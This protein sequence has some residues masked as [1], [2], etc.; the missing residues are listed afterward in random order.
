MNHSQS[1]QYL[2]SYSARLYR[3]IFWL[4]AVYNLSFGLWA[5]FLP[6]LFFDLFKLEPPQY[7]AI[8]QCLGMVIG[9]YGIL[10]GYAALRLERATPIIAVG[11]LGKVLGVIGW[12]LTVGYGEF[13]LRTFTLI[14]L[15]DI[16][17]WLPFALFITHRTRAGRWIRGIAPYACAAFLFLASTAILFILQGVMEGVPEISARKEYI[18]QNQFMWR[19]GW[20]IFII[21]MISIGGFYAW[22]GAHLSS[23]NLAIA[24]L[25]LIIISVSSDLLG[26]SLSLAWTPQNL[27]TIQRPAS[28][29]TAGFANGLNTIA[30]VILTLGTRS[31]RGWLLIF[32]WTVWIIGFGLSAATLANSIMGI[33]VTAGLQFTIYPLWVAVFGWKLKRESLA[34]LGNGVPKF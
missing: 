33:Y 28:I 7:Q 25:M 29:L 34:S 3:I 19:F 8:W 2:D 12:I 4:A 26:I 21:A 16:I 30:G 17:W 1:L 11:L 24:A 9:V 22:W 14:L 10:Y 18:L 31:L 6:Q 15:N 5:I 32:T 20:S 27:E 23:Q 13:P